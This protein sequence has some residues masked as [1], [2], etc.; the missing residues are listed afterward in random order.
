[1]FFFNSRVVIPLTL[2][3]FFASSC[4]SFIF[5]YL[6][7]LL[8]DYGLSPLQSTFIQSISLLFSAFTLPF[9][10]KQLDSKR[11]YLAFVFVFILVSCGIFPIILKTSLH[12]IV[13]SIIFFIS[14]LSTVNIMVSRVTEGLA[15]RN[16]ISKMSSLT[17]MTTNLALG[18]SSI[19]GYFY[20]EKYQ[21]IL[22]LTDII[23]SLLF[24]TF[25]YLLYKLLS[26]QPR[27]TKRNYS[28]N[29]INF[30]HFF[31]QYP[32]IV[33]FIVFLFITIY[34]HISAIPLLYL[35]KSLPAKQF[36]A[37][38]FFVNTVL[39]ATVSY[40]NTKSYFQ[41][42]VNKRVFVVCITS[43]L[44]YLIAPYL[45]TKFGIIISTAIWSFGEALGFPL[46]AEL[47]INKYTPE[48]AGLSV[49]TRDF[50]IKTALISVPIVSLVVNYFNIWVF[51]LVFGGFPLISMFIFFYYGKN[52][53]D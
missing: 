38:L 15:K 52:F 23:T 49:A 50:I 42:S 22:L 53:N 10:G 41:W 44:G 33:F 11:Y 34:S 30:T 40:L 2:I 8:K 3:L 27:D 19:I 7:L 35:K 39:I 24:I 31:K 28:V 32:H 12:I 46:I 48:Q 1:M 20:L 6:I 14:G 47:V 9:F 5:P 18:T 29:I 25:L 36:L 43:S 51:S 4:F 13:L 21:N 26:T 17:Y 16:T 45:L 37:I